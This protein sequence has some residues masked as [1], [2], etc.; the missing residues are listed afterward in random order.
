MQSN[1]I[2]LLPRAIQFHQNL[3]F[4]AQIPGVYAVTPVYSSLGGLSITHLFH[5]SPPSSV[6][7]STQALVRFLKC[8]PDAVRSLQTLT[9]HVMK[10]QATPK[11]LKN[12]CKSIAGKIGRSNLA[13]DFTPNK[14][15]K[16][17]C[18]KELAELIDTNQN[19]SLNKSHHAVKHIC[20]ISVAIKGR[21]TLA[22]RL[23]PR[24]TAVFADCL[25]ISSRPN[26]IR[27]Q[28]N[29]RIAIHSATR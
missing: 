2:I 24:L 3:A 15:G 21:I 27:K 28:V 7:P 20:E 17:A 1:H 18:R 19:T 12:R 23:V 26:I 25:S 22:L 9:E 14:R 29:L 5:N 11:I 10:A 6:G 13:L 8:P 16:T 4:L